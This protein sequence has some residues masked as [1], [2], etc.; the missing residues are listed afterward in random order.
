M[1]PLFNDP[2][3]KDVV[4][5]VDAKGRPAG[6]Y[7]DIRTGI[8]VLGPGRVEFSIE[9]GD[10]VK[11]MVRFRGE[12][13]NLQREPDGNMWSAVCENVEPGFY[14]VYFYID[15]VHVVHPLRSVVTGVFVR[16]IILKWKI[17]S[18]RIIFKEC[19]TWKYQANVLQVFHRW[20]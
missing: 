11:V 6:S 15:D 8:T 19:T 9:A 17:R 16:P 4:F 3:Y 13:V 20:T 12:E 14:Y 7:V 18:F 2:F 1:N 10:A 5:H